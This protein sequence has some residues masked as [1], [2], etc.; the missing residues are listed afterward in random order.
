MRVLLVNTNRY[1]YPDPVPPLGLATLAASLH[2][3][4]HEYRVL[5]L[6][7]ADDIEA[8]IADSLGEGWAQVAGL[9]I[10]NI[11][12]SAY[13]ITYTPLADLDRIIT[14]FR[15]EAVDLPL[16]FGGA[17]FSLIPLP[18]MERYDVDYGVVGEGEL[19][20]PAFLDALDRGNDPRTLP[21]IV[22]RDRSTGSVFEGEPAGRLDPSLIPAA[23][24]Q[25]FA[26]DRYYREGGMM[27]LQ[28]KR[29]C[30]FKCTFCTYPI[31]EGGTE[32]TRS[33]QAVADEIEHWLS[34]GVR[35]FFF[36]D[37][38]F[39]FPEAQAI[40]ILEEVKKRQLDIG[41]TAYI[42]PRQV[43]QQFAELA[44]ETGCKEVEMGCDSAS[45]PVLRAFRKG[46]FQKH[47]RRSITN[48]K[49]AGVR[50]AVSLIFA[51]PDETRETA[52][53]TFAVMDELDPAAV[54]AMV[55]VR[56]YPGGLLHQRAID[57]GLVGADE[58]LLQP[59]F[60]FSPKLDRSAADLIFEE[61]R[62]RSH[63]ITPGDKDT[64]QQTML[65][66]LRMQKGLKGPLW[67]FLHFGAG[68]D[69]K[70]TPDLGT[71]N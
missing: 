45:D 12:N 53:E 40:G 35:D 24:W 38:V 48:L 69:D 47:I 49:A 41:W 8:A 70:V 26:V 71:L 29:G 43:S 58:Q 64:F 27:N 33:P 21:G 19:V 18:F 57:E 7:F 54:I 67:R 30:R 42:N 34:E 9:S 59:T 62:R 3:Q 10:R 39:N 6:T 31:L 46:F 28:T 11:D 23:L 5:D 37:S 63:W 2:A 44:A 4:G 56:I 66:R 52:R 17:G 68:K 13:P 16:V 61:C 14:A 60:Y 51:G 50:T 20:F 36:V 55:G 65:E 32:R 1:T 25:G 15:S 22:W